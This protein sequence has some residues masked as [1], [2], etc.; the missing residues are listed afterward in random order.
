MNNSEQTHHARAADHLSC[1]LDQARQLA[2]ATPTPS[3]SLDW[4]LAAQ[5]VGEF[6]VLALARQR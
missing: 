5:H 1:A 6:S 4:M 2:E 3:V